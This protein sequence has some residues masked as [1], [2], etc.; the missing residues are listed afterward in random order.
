M[1]SHFTTDTDLV[2][3]LIPTLIQGAAM[4]F[5]FIPLTT[6]TLSG[7]PPERMPAA[8]GLSNFVRITAGALGTSI[9]TTL[10]ENR[11]VMHHAHLTER[12][13]KG[14]PVTTGWLDRLTGAGLSPEQAMAQVN[15]LIDQQAYTRAA[16]DI[17]LGSSFL[18]LALIVMIWFTARPKGAAA[19]AGGAH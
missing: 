5:F 4:S 11:A 18:F 8:A 9:S 19:D 17:F 1:R 10:W 14:D 2:S 16:D 7:I 15:R 12:L 3:I 6:I 13:A